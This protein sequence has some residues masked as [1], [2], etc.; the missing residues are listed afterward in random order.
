[1]ECGK[2]AKNIDDNV[3]MGRVNYSG[4]QTGRS[5]KALIPCG[6]GPGP[7]ASGAAQVCLGRVACCWWATFPRIDGGELFWFTTRLLRERKME[8]ETKREKIPV[9]LPVPGSGVRDPKRSAPPV[10]QS[11]AYRMPPL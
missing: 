5:W 11:P 9:W 8:V 2:L 6:L 4:T 1:M 7:S 3:I 10:G